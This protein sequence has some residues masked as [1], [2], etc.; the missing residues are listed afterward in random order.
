MPY[1]MATNSI[2]NHIG[3]VIK[4]EI[5][6][7]NYLLVNGAVSFAKNVFLESFVKINGLVSKKSLIMS[8]RVAPDHG[9]YGRLSTRSL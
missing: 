8:T 7:T 6:Q 9:S 4:V 1:L 2:V 3:L 5:G